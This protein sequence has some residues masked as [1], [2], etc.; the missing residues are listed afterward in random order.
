[1]QQIKDTKNSKEI[2]LL[3]YHRAPIGKNILYRL[4]EVSLKMKDIAE[5]EEF[6]RNFWRL[7]QM[8]TPDISSSTK[9][10]KEK[11]VSLDEQIKIWR[12]TKKK[13]LQSAGLMNW[14]NCIIR[15]EILRSV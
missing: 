2:F 10:A 8:I 7:H 9:S 5:A 4:I 13:N 11:Q 12:N 1:M 15:M 3:A 6:M 14:Q